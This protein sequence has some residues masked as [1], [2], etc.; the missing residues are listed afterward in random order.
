MR[1]LTLIAFPLVVVPS[2]LAQAQWTQVATSGPPA[3]NS[4][5]LVHDS[6]RGVAVLYGGFGGGV[7]SDTWEWNGTAWTQ[8]LASSPPGIL[9]GHAMAYDA[10]RR[11][12]VLFGGA[13]ASSLGVGETWEWDGIN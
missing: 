6:A 10:N 11:V 1:I 8:R 9:N 13:R 2:L 5:A 3:R 7:Q 12:T 4:T